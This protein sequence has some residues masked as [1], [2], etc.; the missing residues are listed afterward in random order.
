VIQVS[1]ERF[2]F[3]FVEKGKSVSQSVVVSSHEAANWKIIKVETSL[4]EIL[5]EVA[6]VIAGQEYRV[7]A[8]LLSNKANSNIINGQV[9][10]YTDHPKQP[11]V[12][13]PIYAIIR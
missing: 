2:F 4:P 1:P 6:P 5:I 13:I 8:K 3:G 10:L 9:K 12:E 11:V 7:D